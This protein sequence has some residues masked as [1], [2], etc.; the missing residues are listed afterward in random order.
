MGK[1]I[2]LDDVVGIEGR[3]LGGLVREGWLRLRGVRVRRFIL[4]F[5]LRGDL[6]RFWLWLWWR[7]DG[8]GEAVKVGVVGDGVPDALAP[9]HEGG[10]W[11]FGVG[12]CAGEGCFHG[13]RVG[14]RECARAWWAGHGGIGGTCHGGVEVGCVQRSVVWVGLLKLEGTGRQ[15]G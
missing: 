5:L 14:G 13:E 8:A 7:N 10:G 6:Q 2:G 4:A 12:D 3:F 1:G 15:L 9:G 11:G